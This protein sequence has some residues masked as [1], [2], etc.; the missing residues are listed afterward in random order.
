MKRFITIALL[1]S[2]ITTNLP[3]F[4]LSVEKSEHLRDMRVQPTEPQNAPKWID[5]VPAKYENPRT[6]FKK[7]TAVAELTVGIILTDLIITCPIGIPMICHGTT[8]LKNISYSNK[9]EKFFNGIEESKKLTAE[10][11][12]IYYKKLLKDCKMK[13]K[14]IDTI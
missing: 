7:G 9:K 2:F 1:L 5:Y 10:E 12:D 3:T 11:Q 6:D 8:K 13:K 4:A 14:Y